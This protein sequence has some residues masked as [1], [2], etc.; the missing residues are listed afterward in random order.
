MDVSPE[1]HPAHSMHGGRI[2]V[3]LMDAVLTRVRVAIQRQVHEAQEIAQR[4]IRRRQ[5]L[6]HLGGTLRQS[7]P[8]P[9]YSRTSISKAIY[10]RNISINGMGF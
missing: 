10:D 6:L 3:L 8:E 9:Y 2:L 5:L 1:V 4:S 7:N